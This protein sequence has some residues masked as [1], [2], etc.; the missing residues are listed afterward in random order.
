MSVVER[1]RKRKVVSPI[2]EVEVSGVKLKI[3]RISKMEL[4]KAGKLSNKEFSEEGLKSDELPQYVSI[5]GRM[6]A[7]GLILKEHVKGW[8]LK[9]EA[10]QDEPFTKESLGLFFSDM[11]YEER[12]QLGI[13]YFKT[14]E[15]DEDQ[16]KMLD[17]CLKILNGSFETDSTTS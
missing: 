13:E 6:A 7:I 4:E 8:N 1:F 5:L 2:V 14:C 12:A 17:L 15:A 10:D 3:A 11:S 16:K 9:N